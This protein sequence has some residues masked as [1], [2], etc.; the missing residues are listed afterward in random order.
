MIFIAI[1]KKKK[2]LAVPPDISG[3]HV[4]VRS[5]MN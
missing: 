1:N 5:Y 3:E 2:N 4:L